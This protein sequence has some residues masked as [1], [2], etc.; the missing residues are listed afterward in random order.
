MG[1]FHYNVHPRYTAGSPAAVDPATAKRVVEQEKEAY[2]RAKEGVLGDRDRE[3]AEKEGLALIVFTMRERPKGWE[4]HD[5][6]TNEHWFWPFEAPCLYCSRKKVPVKRGKLDQHLDL[7]YGDCKQGAG[8]F[9]GRK[10]ER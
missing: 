9:V 3:T 10:L 7:T 5:L 2:E 4:V 1:A 6:I 8:T